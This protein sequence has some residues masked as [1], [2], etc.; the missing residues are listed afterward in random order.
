[1]KSHV[2]CERCIS[3]AVCYKYPAMAAKVAR[4][5]CLNF[6]DTDFYVNCKLY[7]GM[8]VYRYVDFLRKVIEC[9]VIDVSIFCSGD[10]IWYVEYICEAKD[11]DGEL[12]DFYE[13]TDDDVGSTVFLS[14]EEAKDRF[15]VKSGN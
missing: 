13:F 1:M 3:K 11:G 12:I 8:K 9:E 2:D 7:K 5:G 14:L 6:R 15:M 10:D 4:E